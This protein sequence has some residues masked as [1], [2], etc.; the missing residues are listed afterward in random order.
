M[1]IYD[2]IIF[3]IKLLIILGIV[4]H[5]YKTNRFESLFLLIIPMFLT[6]MEMQLDHVDA[7]LIYLFTEASKEELES[8]FFSGLT[9]CSIIILVF[10]LHLS[11]ANT[12]SPKKN[13][14]SCNHKNKSKS[15]SK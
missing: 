15:C 13:C 8:A 4:S 5:I 14:C 6:G 9:F 3:G 11:T 2:T 12:A 7:P 10:L 1:I